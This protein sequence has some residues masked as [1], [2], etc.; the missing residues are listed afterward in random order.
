MVEETL[1][2]IHHKEILFLMQ[3]FTT[4]LSLVLYFTTVT[5]HASET[6][7]QFVLEFYPQWY[8]HEDYTVQGNVGIAKDFDS[9]DDW[10]QYYAKPSFA[11]ALDDQWGLHGGLGLYYTNYQNSDNNTEIRPF[12]GISHFHPLT[13]K[14]R[15]STYFRA[16]ER[17]QD[18][19]ADSLRLRLRFRTA[20]SFNP[21]SMK[22]SW[23]KF[24]FDVEGFKSHFEEENY[25]NSQDTYDYE[26]HI[27][28]GM[29]RSLSKKDKVRFELAWKYK[30][31][32]EEISNSSVNTI[33]FKIQYYP[34]W[35]GML[36][37][38]L[39]NRG[40]DE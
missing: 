36:N 10:V 23:H 13:E 19:T 35:G 5:L 9:D 40:I 1:I 29:E 8:S 31:P 12:L 3:K 11:Y 18:T 20:Y 37:N 7:K 4:S 26:T 38:K 21:L 32:P 28:L 2:M 14:W 16:E 25:E 30:S 24:T 6:E 33:Y 39:F 17:Y 15:L 27:T 22:D 34:I